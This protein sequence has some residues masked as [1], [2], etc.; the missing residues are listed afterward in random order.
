MLIEWLTVNWLVHCE[1]EMDMK[2]SFKSQ[3]LELKMKL[4]KEQ[5]CIEF[6]YCEEK[7]YIW[8]GREELGKIIRLLLP[9]GRSPKYSKFRIILKS[10]EQLC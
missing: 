5:S 9:P 7:G 3:W 10:L 1:K 6:R 4:K 2:W 8:R